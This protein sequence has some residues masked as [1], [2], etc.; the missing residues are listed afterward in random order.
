MNLY[1]VDFTHIVTNVKSGAKKQKSDWTLAYGSCE[2]EAVRSAKAY[3]LENLTRLGWYGSVRIDKVMFLFNQE[4][5]G[6][7][8]VWE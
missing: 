6:K 4:N 2:S 7:L 8:E 3:V 1:R 5:V